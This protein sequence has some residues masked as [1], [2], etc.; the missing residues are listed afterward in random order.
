MDPV[1]LQLA[2]RGVTEIATVL[3][4]LFRQ[5]GR[6]EDAEKLAALTKQLLAHSDATLDRIIARGRDE[7]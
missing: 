4:P 5:W 1:T 3:I 6:D 7:G 2:I